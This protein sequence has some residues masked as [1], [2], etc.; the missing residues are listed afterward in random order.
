MFKFQKNH[1]KEVPVNARTLKRLLTG[2]F[3]I[4]FLALGVFAQYPQKSWQQYE[5]PEEAGF[6]SRKLKEAK[7]MYDK[8]DTAAFLV[9]YKGRV[10]VSWGDV[11]RRYMCHSVRKSLLSALYGIYVDRGVINLDKTMADLNIDDKFPLS[12]EE[13]QATI[14]HL[15]KARSGVYHPAA[16]ES[17]GMKNLRPKRGGH[18]PGTFWYYNNWDF[19]TLAAIFRQ[20]TKTGVFKAFKKDLAKPLQ[21]EDFRLLDGYYHLEPEHSNFPAYPFKMSARDLARLGYLFLMKGKWNGNRIISE[22]WIKEST[23]TYSKGRRYLGYAYLWWTDKPFE[24]K[25]GMY[26]ARGVGAQHIGV[27]P[28][29]EL[30]I[31]QRVD[32]YRGKQAWVNYKLIQAIMDARTGKAKANPK[33]IPL[34]NTPSYT[35]PPIISLKKDALKKYAKEYEVRGSKVNVKLAGETLVLE[36]HVIGN[37]KL[38]PVSAEQFI[39]E[40]REQIGIFELD[41]NGA[42]TGLGVYTNREMADLFSNIKKHGPTKAIKKYIEKLK[43]DKEAGKV[44]EN[45]LNSLG[46]ELL[47]SKQM[48]AAI[49]VFKLNTEFFPKSWNTYD[50]LAEAYMKNGDTKPA[51]FNYKKSLELNPKNNNAKAMLEKLKEKK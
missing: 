20:E 30:V 8:M 28:G 34:R 6:S 40:D 18:K 38:L 44:S 19:N 21:M 14:R 35:R 13:K 11:T 32:T 27:L 24:D 7:A 26:S 16:Y 29:A 10:V 51:I 41:E 31:V 33:L 22:K 42:P 48:E 15:L 23:K 36:S 12:K 1:S 17:Q 43:Q 2:L 45:E 5:T 3:I 37:F 50:S 4:S 49:A 9:I 25:G 47:G 39:L 46:Y